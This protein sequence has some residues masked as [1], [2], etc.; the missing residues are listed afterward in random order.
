MKKLF[1][2]LFALVATTA[3]WAADF[4]VDGI[5]YNLL[6]DKTNEVEVTRGSPNSD[7]GDEYSGSVTIPATVTYKGTT[8]SVT[9]IGIAAFWDCESLT[10]ITIP[11]S[12]TSIANAAFS[13]TGIYNDDSNWENG[14]LYISNCLITVKPDQ[15]AATYTIKD[16]TRLIADYAFYECSG[17]T[18]VTIPNSVTS[19]GIYAFYN[20][21]GLTSVTIGNSVTSIGIYAFYNCSG[22]TSITIGNSVTSIGDFAFYY[23]ESLTSITIPNSVISIGNEAFRYC[24]GLTSVTI[25]NSVTSIKEDAFWGCSGLTSVTIGNSVTSIGDGA[26]Y[27]CRGLTSVTIPNSVTSIGYEAFANCSGLTFIES[28]AEVPPTLGTDAFYNV[29]KNIPV[30]VP[31]GSVS[32]YQS[33]EGWK[34]FTNIQE[35]LVEYSIAVG[36]NDRIMGTSKVDYNT[37]CEDAQI[38][39]TANYGYHF[40]QWS[41]GNTDNPRT[42][43]LTQDTIL[44]AEFALTLSGQC[45]D[46]LYWAYGED[47]KKISITGSGDMYNYTKSTQPWL[48]FQE[49]ITEVTTSNTT[50]SIGA[51]AFEGCIRLGKVSLGS[52]MENIAANAFAACKRLYDIYVYASYPPFAEES[53]F[54]NYNVYLYIPCENQRDYILDV[55]WGNFKFIECI[56][57]ES[58]NMGGDSVVINTGSTDVTIIWPT[59][60]NADTYSIVIK[61]DGKVVCTLTFNS[62]GQLLNIAFAPGREGNH[63]AQYAE[64]TTNGYRF[65]VTGLEDGTDYTYDITVKD[66]ANKTISEHSGEFTTNSA[67]ALDNTHSQSPITNCQKILR[68]GQ[69]II[70]RDGVEYNAIGMEL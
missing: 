50:T 67:T 62:E 3:L 1:T 23:C 21:S 63:P 13:N 65:T 68:N 28:L 46:N 7:Y 48:L 59:E 44:T 20:C 8:Y 61:K 26:F 37:Y 49:Q 29:P 2:L 35:P 51:S 57:A 19:I 27:G 43:V 53:S 69:L 34:A 33:A 25:P 54:A 6:T 47:N 41:D 30:Y 60:E 4:K 40:V 55:V 22:L 15:V 5:Y 31:C 16:G 11:N 17:L 70:L 56:G 12:V 14:V 58:E 66:A 10:S 45:G 18:S 52:N 64:A 38:S 9:S 39:A 32:A 36:V 24:S 42:L